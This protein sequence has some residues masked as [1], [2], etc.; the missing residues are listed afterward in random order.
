MLP[1]AEAA[2]AAAQTLEPK[3]CWTLPRANPQQRK[4][5]ADALSLEAARVTT[6]DVNMLR[7]LLHDE[8][9]VIHIKCNKH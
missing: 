7:L 5:R 3:K 9:K 1:A 6:Y 2:V 8:S 4:A